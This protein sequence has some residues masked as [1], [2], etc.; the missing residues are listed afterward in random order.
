MERRPL[1]AEEIR[2]AMLLASGDLQLERPV[3]SPVMELGN[4]A[5]GGGKGAKGIHKNSD[6]RSV[7]LPYM[8]GQVP[9]MLQVF[10]G[11]DPDL[12]VGK[13]DV[14][15]VPTQAL[16]LMNNPFVLKQSQAIAKRVL[17][18][19][20]RDQAARIVLAFRL[21]L[22]RAPSEAERSE[23]A[24]FLKEYRD[25]L[26]GASKQGN[27]QLAAWTSVCQTLLQSGEFRYLY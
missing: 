24:K 15:I 14:T 21:V 25:A 20:E 26:S 13:R 19:S 3:G 6:V 2:D 7:Y 8:R 22:C 1:E 4:A 5:L 27:P 23:V 11:A 18:G 12:I 10:D 16:L 9:E 17:E